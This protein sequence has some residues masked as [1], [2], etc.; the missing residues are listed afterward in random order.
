MLFYFSSIDDLLRAG[1]NLADN[2]VVVNKETS[3]SAEEE[4]LADCNTIVAVQ[5]IFRYALILLNPIGKTGI[6]ANN[7]DPDERLHKMAF[8]EGLHCL[9]KTNFRDMN[10]MCHK[11]E[12]LIWD[13]LKHKKDYPIHCTVSV[14]FGK[15]H[16]NTINVFQHQN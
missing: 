16:Q 3:N 8:H 10:I 14:C 5:T 9:L 7:E 2:V 6:L 15:T 11:L 13:S 12:I 1:I 4:T